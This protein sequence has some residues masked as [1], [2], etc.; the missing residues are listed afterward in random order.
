MRFIIRVVVNAFAIWV[1]TLIPVLQVTVTAFPPAQMLQFVLTL[2]AVGAIFA[3]VNTII[4]TVVKI[5]AFP[6]YIL[7]LGLIGFIIN[8]FLLWL[9]AWIT[10]GFGWGL[11]VGSFWW[12]VL[13]ALIISIINA[14]F[15]FVLRPQEKRSRRD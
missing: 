6:L 8:G 1:V 10:S 4:G 7:T 3:L 15:G 12:G 9:T 2:L 13:A 11:S 14:I 5:V